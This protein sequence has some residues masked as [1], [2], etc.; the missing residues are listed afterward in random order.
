MHIEKDGDAVGVESHKK[1]DAELQ[2]PIS[3][4]S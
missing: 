3:E 4:P 1:D 2:A